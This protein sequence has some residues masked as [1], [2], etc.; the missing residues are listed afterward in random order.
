MVG[1]HISNG[2]LSPTSIWI[3]TETKNYVRKPPK[4]HRSFF[5]VEI[6]RTPEIKDV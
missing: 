2:G 4:P 5:M 1:E 6:Y 3:A